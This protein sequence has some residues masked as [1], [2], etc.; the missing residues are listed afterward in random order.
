V[1]A[2]A[3]ED[4]LDRLGD[5]LPAKEAARVHEDVNALIDDRIEAALASEPALT[6][7]AAERQALAALGS[8]EK[9]A[10]HLVASP[11]IIPLATRRGFVRLLAAVFA[12]HLLLSIAL[13]V[14]GAQGPAIGHLLGPLPREAFADV[15]IAVLSIFLLDA[16]ALL[17]IFVTIGKARP[18]KLLP[19]LPRHRAWTRRG[20]VEGLVLLT[21]LAIIFNAF[22]DRIF[23]VKIGPHYEPFLAPDL[24]AIVPLVNVPFAFFALR[25][26]LTLMGRARR[27]ASTMADAL[28]SLSASVVLVLA[29]TRGKLVMMPSGSRL[30]PEAAG[31]LD[32]LIERVFLLV[33]VV[34]A[35]W[36]VVRFVQE[37]IHFSHQLRT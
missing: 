27:P 12:G 33:F 6:E 26:I 20:A 10:D 24:K 14:A 11:L 29:A 23:A 28:G 4:Y 17:M 21:L 25:H 8:P 22:L 32:S 13:T 1:N 37:A 2:G 5:L 16:G 31:V 3:R 9:L 7:A 15:A 35:I 30:G 18:G 19:V 34:A 36:L